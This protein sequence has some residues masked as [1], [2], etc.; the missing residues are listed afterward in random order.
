M[1]FIFL[2]SNATKT[3]EICDNFVDM[4]NNKVK[5][6]ID[7]TRYNLSEISRHYEKKEFRIPKYQRGYV[8]D[9][10]RRGKLIDSILRGYPIGSII[11]WNNN[12]IKYVLDGQQRTRSLMEIRNFPFKD[13]T[14]ETF[15][16]LFTERFVEKN[17]TMLENVLKELKKY[18]I[19]QL[20]VE[21]YDEDKTDLIKRLVGKN[22]TEAEIYGVDQK[23][24][25]RTLKRYV[26]KLYNG[27]IF[28]IPAIEITEGSEEDAIE[29]FDRLNSQGIELTRMEKLAAR[30]SS[31]IVEL[32]DPELLSIIKNIYRSD[33]SEDIRDTEENTPSELI[34]ALLLNSFKGTKFFK[35]LF[36]DIDKGVEVLK[37]THI[38]KLLWLIRV[39]VI[40][41]NDQD[42]SKSL[43][44]SFESDILLGKELARIINDDEEW[45]K[46]AAHL[47]SETWAKIEEL[48]PILMKEQNGKFIFVNAASTNLFVSMASQIFYRFLENDRATINNKLQL[49]LIREIINGSYESSTNKVVKDTISSEEYLKEIDLQDVR[50]KL[51]EVNELQKEEI[52]LKRGFSNVAKLVISLAYS[53]FSNNKIDKYDY[54]HV[55]PK[56]WLK[57]SDLSRGQNSIGNCGILQASLNREKQ[58]SVVTSELLSDKLTKL[59][60]FE[61][62]GYK[63][64]I[65]KIK[66]YKERK[67]FERF[68]NMRFDFISERFLKNIDPISK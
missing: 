21:E 23:D 2:L 63:E 22:K 49:V 13:M 7:N 6:K 41:Y 67:D 55:F 40:K 34:W 14:Q 38:D 4:Q 18:D 53:E 29:I 61:I 1:V 27:E 52:N 66:V 50:K 37:H 11:I 25:I 58:D 5:V 19:D 35:S 12:N 16:S 68:L 8:W 30:W 56:N 47:L 39:M 46:N 65:D 48:C 28:E 20:Y 15:N 10:S 33:D 32:K 24:V 9:S 36:T 31:T 60:G 59:T 26:L 3:N 17:N 45:V 43:D 54:D 42:L 57:L 44:D 51:I 64:Q 62:E